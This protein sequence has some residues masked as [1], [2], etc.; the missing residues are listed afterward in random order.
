MTPMSI[1]STVARRAKLRGRPRASSRMVLD[2]CQAPMTPSATS[3][4][5]LTSSSTPYDEVQALVSRPRRVH[6][7]STPLSSKAR[8]VQ[9]ASRLKRGTACASTP[10]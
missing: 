1:T 10:G 8:K 4:A 9:P 3:P 6:A 2:R 5:V 7:P